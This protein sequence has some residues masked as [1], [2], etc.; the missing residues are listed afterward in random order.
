MRFPACGSEVEEYYTG[1]QGLGTVKLLDFH[2]EFVGDSCA[3][4]SLERE[5]KVKKPF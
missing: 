5:N 2:I 3:G 4:L 1:S